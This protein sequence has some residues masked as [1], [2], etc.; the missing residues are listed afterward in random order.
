LMADAQPTDL[1]FALQGGRANR[2]KSGRSF[3]NALEHAS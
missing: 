3:E 2:E 1:L